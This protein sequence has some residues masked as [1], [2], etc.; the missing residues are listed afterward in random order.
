MYNKIFTFKNFTNKLK[1]HAVY[2]LDLSEYDNYLLDINNSIKTLKNFDVELNR[3]KDLLTQINI[4]D[5]YISGAKYKDGEN[6]E[7]DFSI[8]VNTLIESI[9]EYYKQI[10]KNN[11]ETYSK[12][13]IDYFDGEELNL[14][15]DIEIEKERFNK[16]HFPINLPNFLKNI[17][18]G[19][20]IVLKAIIEFEYCLFNKIDDSTDL[21]FV[22]DSIRNKEINYFSF[23]KDS[24][25]LIFNDNYETI[26]K[27]LPKWLKD[28]SEYFVLDKDF[29]KNIKMKSSKMF[30]HE[31]YNDFF[32]KYNIKNV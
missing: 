3:L 20:K 29:Y 6:F 21:K 28:Y 18:L 27:I 12:I 23:E 11:K 5:I 26:L 17:G 9:K 4:D 14:N 25:I 7:L 22:V 2:D 16:F 1:E 10:K 32:N 30:L 8:K 13:N 31:I 19:K 15:F 24:N